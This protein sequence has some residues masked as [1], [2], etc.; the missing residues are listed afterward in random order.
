MEQVWEGAEQVNMAVATI[1]TIARAYVQ[2][3]TGFPIR[4]YFA[5][6]SHGRRG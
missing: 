6:I 1:A 3:E 4:V 2:V 5:C